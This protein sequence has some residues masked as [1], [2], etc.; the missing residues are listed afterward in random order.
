MDRFA[1]DDVDFESVEPCRPSSFDS[2]GSFQFD[3]AIRARQA[4]EGIHLKVKTSQAKHFDWRLSKKT[5]DVMVHRLEEYSTDS[6]A[7]RV[8]FRISCE[9][10]AM[11]ESIVNVLAPTTTSEYMRV[12]KRVFPKF[13]QCA[14]LK[15]GQEGCNEV[16]LSDFSASFPRHTIKW[17][18]SHL[19][20]NRITGRLGTPAEFVF[21]EY[22]ELETIHG[23][24][25]AFGFLQSV[26][27]AEDE[28]RKLS[29]VKCKRG[30]IRKSSFL[31]TPLDE[32]GVTH[33]VALM[34][35]LDFPKS[36]GV[37]VERVV[38]AYTE[39]LVNVREI[40]FNTL[41]HAI[42][43]LPRHKWVDD[44]SRQYCAVCESSFT[45]VRSRHH[46]RAC[47]EVIC[48]YCSRKWSIP[49]Q[50]AGE[51]QT[52]LCT[53]CSL[54]ARSHLIPAAPVT[55]PIRM[56]RSTTSIEHLT[57]APTPMEDFDYDDVIHSMHEAHRPLYTMPHKAAS[58]SFRGSGSVPVL[59]PP[60]R[61]AS[62]M[63]STSDTTAA[64]EDAWE[65]LVCMLQQHKPHFVFVQYSC[66]HSPRIVAETLQRLH[67]DVV[68]CGNN[69]GAVDQDVVLFQE[70][71]FV[72]KKHALS[73]WGLWDVDGN[74]ATAGGS[75][76]ETQAKEMTRHVLKEGIRKLQLG[77]TES[78]DFV[79]I[80]LSEGHEDIVVETVNVMLDT[81]ISTVGASSKQSRICGMPHE[82][83]VFEDDSVVLAMCCPSVHVSHA[84]FTCY[85]PNDRLFTVG[86]AE[87]KRLLELD[88]QPPLGLLKEGLDRHRRRLYLDTSVFPAFGRVQKKDKT[89]QLIEP[90]AIHSDLTMTLSAPVF[91]GDQVCL[92]SMDRKIVPGS[93]ASRIQQGCQEL[94]V[95]GCFVSCST[96][97]VKHLGDD[98][99]QLRIAIQNGLGGDPNVAITGSLST[100][101]LG[102]ASNAH[103][104]SQS[105]GMVAALMISTKK[106]SNWRPR[107]AHRKSF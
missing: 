70:E 61:V 88:S 66:D 10:K 69:L 59:P 27:T 16:D 1:V 73:L 36:F 96:S 4:L 92:M 38:A 79:W 100:C 75:F 104:L 87:G 29:P 13:L 39:R 50:D 32:Q 68:F 49:I 24:T 55:G 44:R 57:T 11:L 31:V 51:L 45:I 19:L 78:P 99:D 89:R 52:R 83:H 98:Y 90:V 58:M 95:V 12:E 71:A 67:P 81:S 48:H 43:I 35:I 18:A 54:R 40:L 9:V 101:Q 77:P 93:I 33:E 107:M 64:V 53:P 103:H 14:V 23:R 105:N 102:A 28:L 26:E 5:K 62:A 60:V 46:C 86:K 22:V 91:R 47:G 85:E 15:E 80:I 63:S 97:I 2:S 84:Y 82:T 72:R 41:F 56:S 3:V 34:Y 25:R 94:D 17:H 37:S 74:F 21:E 8:S 7:T 30:T 6:V 76:T 20:T 106:K 42:K 65:K